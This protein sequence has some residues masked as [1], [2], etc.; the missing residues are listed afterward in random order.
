[1][2]AQA[3]WTLSEK[4]SFNLTNHA[5]VELQGKGTVQLKG[6]I[7]SAQLPG[8]DTRHGEDYMTLALT[9]LKKDGTTK[10]DFPTGTVV[11]VGA[12]DYAATENKCLISL[13]KVGSLST[14]VEAALQMKNWGLE[15]G[16]YIIRVGLYCA[17]VGGYI[18]PGKA[19]MEVDIPLS[20]KEKPAYGLQVSQAE[21]SG[22]I[23]LP[24]AR[25]PTSWPMRRRTTRSL[26]R[27]CT[28][29]NGDGYSSA[30]VQGVKIVFDA[31]NR[32]ATVTLPQALAAGTYRLMF[33]MTT[34]GET[35]TVPCQIIVQP[36]SSG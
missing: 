33:T 17:S 4:R 13:G 2:T 8:N 32:G 11:R 26:Q 7:T 34:A 22:P 31:D 9:L 23:A 18:A 25:S 20:V 21:G 16:E 19:E 30:A 12:D 24:A 14:D 36:S 3:S 29:K 1:M 6:T 35:Y 10:V 28:P 27:R 5:G 15:T